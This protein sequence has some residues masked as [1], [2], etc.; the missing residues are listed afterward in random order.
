MECIFIQV[1]T[2]VIDRDLKLAVE[3]SHVEFL[4]SDGR[5]ISVYDE[6]TLT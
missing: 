1:S 2:R 3:V 5:A 4:G 6:T